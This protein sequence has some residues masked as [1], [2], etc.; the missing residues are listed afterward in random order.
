MKGTSNGL[1]WVDR[2]PAHLSPI[3]LIRPLGGSMAL[4]GP[5]ADALAS[6][7]RVLEFDAR[8]SGAS[9]G[10]PRTSTAGLAEDAVAVLEA[11]AI[12]RAHVFGISLG[13]M[14]ATRFVLARPDRVLALVLASTAARGLAFEA[15]GLRRGIRFARCLTHEDHAA[16]RC[17]VRRVLSHQFRVEHPEEAEHIAD[18][19][20]RIPYPRTTILAHAL[21]AARHDARR[22]IPSIR[23]RTLVLAGDRDHLLGPDACRGLAT[24]IPGARRAV[25]PRA[26]HDLT[27][28]NPRDTASRVLEFVRS[29]PS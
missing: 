17:V 19:A 7:H 24:S 5:F 26:G 18:R 20:S 25:V 13:G 2:G 28:E 3:L 4:W 9:P 21:A 22:E 15:A 23:A 6:E 10:R 12:P 14:V 16:E 29:H 27:L 1:A 8:G 11:R